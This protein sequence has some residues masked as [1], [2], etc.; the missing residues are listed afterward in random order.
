MIRKKD[1]LSI[2]D[3]SPEEVNSLIKNAL[4]MKAHKNK[5]L[6]KDKVLALLFEK[7]SLRT[8]VSFSVAMFQLGGNCIF[9]P[10]EEIGIGTREDTSDIAQVLS[11][12]VHGIV[13]R[14]FSH[15]VLEKMA[16]NASIPVINGLSD[17]EHP[18]QAL[19]DI[20]TIFE[21]KGKFKRIKIAYIGDGNNVAHSLALAAILVG[22]DFIISNP[23]GYGLNTE[24]VNKIQ[25]L[26]RETGGRI[27][28]EKDPFKAVKKADIV[29]TDVWTSMGQEAES[30]K[31][32]REFSGY[33]VNAAL[34]AA[35]PS[36][37]L[38]MHPLP[39]HYGEEVQK[40]VLQGPQSIVYD[41]AE[42][43]LH[44]QKAILLH[45]L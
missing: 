24:I 6:L 36:Q 22:M 39:A 34:M 12:Y 38:L 8:K 17:L 40:E 20:L 3:L 42:N 25:K 43:R 21:K 26:S 37:A 45:L 31:R 44:M 5:P 15:Q 35:A 4:Y 7:P 33:Q 30:E 23:P 16:N 1:L 27:S 28:I 32:R 19:S 18:C 11:K 14:T 9:L 29:Y 10:K 41:Q 13:Y 2:S